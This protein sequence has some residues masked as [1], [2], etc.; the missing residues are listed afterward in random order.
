MHVHTIC[1]SFFEICLEDCGGM[2]ID[3][4]KRVGLTDSLIINSL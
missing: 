1:F 2:N 3:L 4:T